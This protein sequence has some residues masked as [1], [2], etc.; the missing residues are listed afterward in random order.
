[1]KQAVLFIIFNR[2]D[3][4]QQVLASIRNYKPDRLYISADGSRTTVAGEHE[5]VE[6]VRNWVISQI[7]WDCELKTLFQDKNLGC[8]LAPQTAISWFFEH[9]EEGIILEDD[10]V[11]NNDFFSFCE[12]MLDYY[13][14]D[15]RIS[16]ISG[17]NFDLDNKYKTSDSYFFSRFPY[18]WGWATWKRNWIDYDYHLTEWKSISK[19]LFLKTNIFKEKKYY[20][21][22]KNKFDDLS[23]CQT[24][25]IWDYQFFYQCF[26]KKQL[27]V[28]PNVNLVSNIGGGAG[29]T[30]TI[31]END[32]MLF[33]PPKGLSFPLEHPKEILRNFSYDEYLQKMNYGEI[34][35]ISLIKQLKRRLKRILKRVK[36]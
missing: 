29:A 34:E 33:R 15:S 3:T 5:K 22:W 11:P 31:K 18:T 13:R 21:V 26:K 27:S 30:H 16:I 12:N 6:L 23:V 24:K 9:E 1:M 17:C 20:Q 2:L 32:P 36:S 14:N 8:G 4:A 25:D 10:C 28:V 7:D 19:D 35:Q